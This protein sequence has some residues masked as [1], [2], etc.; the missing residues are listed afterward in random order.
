VN[1][2][3]LAYTLAAA[4]KASGFSRTRLYGLIGDGCLA[5]FKIGRRTMVKADSLRSLI[6]AL[7]GAVVRPTKAAA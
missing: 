5:A 1:E 7:P 3:P 4:T 2:I 6:D